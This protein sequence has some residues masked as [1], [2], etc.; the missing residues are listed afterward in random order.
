MRTTIRSGLIAKQVV[1]SEAE[2]RHDPGTEVVHD[3]VALGDE[4]LQQPDALGALQVER[5]RPG[6]EV[7][8]DEPGGGLGVVAVGAE[9]VE[10]AR[11]RLDLE[12]LGAVVGQH[13]R[14]VGPG[15]AGR[16][17]D[18]PDAREEAR[19]LDHA[20]GGEQLEVGRRESPS[21]SP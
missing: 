2:A 18:D 19:H 15:D 14:R 4:L 20:A 7:D 3:D 9:R 8:L 17:A 11:L 13:P 10:A 5:D 21:H 6:V 16:Q 1:G 12:H